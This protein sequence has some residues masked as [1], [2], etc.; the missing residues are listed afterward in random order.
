MS[1][2]IAGAVVVGL[3]GAVAVGRVA[4]QAS[5]GWQQYA[6][7]AEAGFSAQQ[8]EAARAY[9][10]SVRTGAVMAV[11]RGR[12][13]AAWGD[14][15]R[16]MP[17]HS[18]RKSLVSA[19]YGAAVARGELRLDATLSDFRIDDHG[20]LTAAEQ[21]ATLRDVISS[22]SGVYL[23][24]AY[25]GAD[26][27][28]TRPARG[29]HAPGT[30]WFYNN[31]DFNVAG[32]V[33]ERATGRSVYTAFDSLIARAIGMEDYSPASGF[34]V[35]EPSLSRH[36]AHT[37]TI[38][39]RDLARFGQLY[40]QQGR[41]QGREV[42]PASWVREST[43]AHTDFGNGTGYGY[44][45]WTYAPGSLG[46]GYQHLD[47]YELYMGRGTGG[48]AVYVIPAAELVIVHR[49]DTENGRGVSGAHAWRIA[50]L[51]LGAREADPKAEPA[52]IA[53]APTAFTSQL[54]PARLPAFV[55]LDA[56]ALDRVTGSYELAPGA[57]LRV[58]EFEGRPFINVPGRGE[59]EL[60]AVSPLEFVIR[61]EAGVRIRFETAAGGAVT[62][63]V[64][65][66]GTQ[67]MRAPKRSER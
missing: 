16:P 30:H 67:E 20:V 14:V 45:W 15:A 22:R 59:A 24:A 44:M 2:L 63:V 10:D 42:I 34:L 3:L 17:A 47:S 4:A 38:S 28:A 40:L 36:P 33:Y 1:R 35:V 62:A 25:A 51:I 31:W 13:V 21:G 32:V 53:L 27:D 41:W 64:V 23:P 37:F 57:V 6:S 61:V 54:P 58:F 39:A 29:S 8:L 65:R 56:A 5:A 19:L 26:Q 60:F 48:Q 9:A 11:Y 66:Q 43:H 55:T 50:E 7:P 49:G 52:T 18:V 12:V 46:A